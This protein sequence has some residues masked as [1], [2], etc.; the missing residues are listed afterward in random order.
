[1][2][3]R[4]A[5]VLLLLLTAAAA[6]RAGGR[7]GLISFRRVP[8]PDDVPAHLCTAMAQDH[9]GLLWLGTQGGLVRYDGH[10]FRVF[11]SSPDKPT[12]LAGNYVRALLIASDG[13]IWV[14]T[15]SGGLSVFDARTETFRRY[16]HDARNP[17]SLAY[18]RVEGLAE[19]RRGRIWIATSAGLDRLDPRSGRIDHFRHDARDARSIADDRVRGLL[20]DREGRLW[21]GSRQG[22][23]RWLGDRRGF[24]R[25]LT[26]QY[27]ERLL[28]DHQGRIWIGTEKNGAAVLNPRDGSLRRFAPQPAD[29]DGLSHYWVYGFAEGP[30]EEMWIATFGGGVDVVDGRSL[31]VIDRLRHDPVLDDTIG[32]D[33]VGAV[34][35]DRAGMMWVGTWGEGLARHDPRTRAFRSLRFSP[36]RADGISHVAAVRAME[37][38]DGRIWVGTNGNG[39]DVLD[40]ELRRVAEYRPNPGDDGALSDGA[41]TCLAQSDDGTIWVAALNGSLHRLLPGETRFDRLPVDRL[42]GG[43][44][45]TIAFTPDGVLWAGAAEGMVRVDPH[46]LA[47]RVY[48]QWP[49]AA[50]SSPAIEA[51]AVGGGGLL[52]IGT[53]NG[54][55]AF[56]P[57][58]E[59][60]ARIARDAARGDALPDNW[61]PD[62]MIA[63]D[64]RLWVGTA[65]GAA[66]LTQWDGRA[67]RFEVVDRRLGR[68]SER[69]ESLIEDD[70]GMVWIG[71]RLRVDP[72]RWTARELGPADGIAF[73]N[74]FIASRARTSDGRLLFG[75]PEG[76]LVADPR[77]LQEASD[78]PPIVATALRVDG[79]MRPGAAVLRSLTLRP[80]ERGFALDF[81]ALDFLESRRWTYRY[82]LDG[83]EDAWTVAGPAQRSLTYSRLPPG[84]YVLR[85]GAARRD[86]EWSRQELRL[87]ITV[88]PAFHQTLWFRSL[89]A[90]AIAAVL[91]GAYRLRIRRLRAR[92]RELERLVTAR[93]GEL[94]EKNRQLEK[95]Y[96]QIEEASLTDPLTRLRNRRYLEQTIGADLEIA[97][98]GGAERDLVLLMIDL[99]HFK[100]VNDRYGHAAGDAVLVELAGLLLRTV[101]AS[102]TVIR[103]GGEEFL[104]VARFVDRVRAP[105][106]AEKVR[107]AVAAHPFVLPDGTSIRRTCSIGFAAW[108][109]S[110]A[111]PRGVDWEQVVDLADSGLYVSKRN[112]R[113]AWTGIV[114]GAGGDAARAAEAY[115]ADPEGAVARGEIVVQSSAMIEA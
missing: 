97:A 112:G 65:G 109:F 39:I 98:R 51:I 87:P 96:V 10:E 19:D 74:F 55:Y 3:R 29:P 52:W 7:V 57:R 1:M 99:D 103:W 42:A 16:Q 24:E 59:V 79:N 95:A 113:D 115:R 33:R 30:A 84:E 5:I 46:T 9:S 38:R 45:R 91:Y 28:E 40:S 76:L 90:V 77:A 94:A 104:I 20:V 54:L 41:I 47:T 108:P 43:P 78:D 23:Q 18:D 69:A 62:L 37:M 107:S 86:G 72:R 93:T 100:S 68:P 110:P 85:V 49:G 14:G 56:D 22:L 101:R 44:I 48:R 6:A 102:D 67:A 50:R 105:E 111:A 26:G 58:T 82:R 70:Q 106:L 64:G 15:F 88:L 21:V 11:R 114:L 63:R 8:I 61:V 60:A 2:R 4:C 75:S 36:R 12:T 25:V 73:R 35:R 80:S 17:A 92:E 32:A 27:V 81:A 34:F 71:P 13:R 89:V 66:V 31:T 83:L 53:D